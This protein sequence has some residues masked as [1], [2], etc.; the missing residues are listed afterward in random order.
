MTFD[1]TAI[2]VKDLRAIAEEKG[3]QGFVAQANADGTAGQVHW[4]QSSVTPDNRWNQKVK[5][6]DIRT[7]E[8]MVSS[9]YEGLPEVKRRTARSRFEVLFERLVSDAFG[10]F[11]KDGRVEWPASIQAKATALGLKPTD[12]PEMQCRV[13]A[14]QLFIEAGHKQAAKDQKKVSLDWHGHYNHTVD[15]SSSIKAVEAPADLVVGA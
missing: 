10:T 11:Y 13:L 4:S 9:L 8:R 2:K 3:R 6:E 15:V 1:P 12:P 14:E 5:G 7:E